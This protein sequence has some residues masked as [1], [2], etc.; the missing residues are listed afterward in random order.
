MNVGGPLQ[1][2]QPSPAGASHVNAPPASGRLVR[3]RA[4]LNDFV[5][6]TCSKVPGTDARH[7]HLAAEAERLEQSLND[8][9]DAAKAHQPMDGKTKTG[10]I[11]HLEK[12]IKVHYE[13]SQWEGTASEGRVKLLQK[14]MDMHDHLQRAIAPR[15]IHVE[16]LTNGIARKAHAIYFKMATGV[17]AERT[18]DGFALNGT[19]CEASQP[20][21]KSLAR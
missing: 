13:L 16:D 18:I 10:L 17:D 19:P 7:I 11:R 21:A 3:A 12:T 5:T 8:A 14:C 6:A 9:I 20:R 4:L 15:D 2:L 1:P